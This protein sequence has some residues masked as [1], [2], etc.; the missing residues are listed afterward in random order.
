[1]GRT[2]RGWFAEDVVEVQECF[3]RKQNDGANHSVR[4]FLFW[5]GGESFRSS[6]WTPPPP[7]PAFVGDPAQRAQVC[8][9]VRYGTL[10]CGMVLWR[11]CLGHGGSEE[12][13]QGGL[14]SRPGGRAGDLMVKWMARDQDGTRDGDRAGLSVA[15]RG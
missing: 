7:P 14:D 5:A 12:G 3:S 6:D 10:G 8:S 4:P 15:E 2:R 9:T 11:R 1:M 13:V